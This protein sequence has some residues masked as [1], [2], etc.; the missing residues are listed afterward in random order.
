MIIELHSREFAR[1]GVRFADV[2]AVLRETGF[3]AFTTKWPHRQVS[4]LGTV[5]YG[6]DVWLQSAR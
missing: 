6:D 2:V 1:L 3:T 5:A 4:D